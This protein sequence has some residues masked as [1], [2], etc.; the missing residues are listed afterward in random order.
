MLPPG[1]TN[2]A[3]PITENERAW[4]E[5]IRLASW[6]QDPPL[7]LQRVQAL[8][9]IFRPGYQEDTTRQPR[10]WSRE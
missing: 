4:I 9:R 3:S 7:T 6:D 8:R 2:Y 10:D 5:I 1:P